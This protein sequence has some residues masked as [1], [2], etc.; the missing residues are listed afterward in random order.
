MK[1]K[2][3]AA[4]RADEIRIKEADMNAK[5]QLE[6]TRLGIEIAKTKDAAQREDEREGVRMG[7][8]IAKNKAQM[9]QQADKPQP[10]A[11]E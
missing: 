11:K 2:L 1:D 7:I 6:G 9:K 3:D 4:A 8:D 5:Q 10:K